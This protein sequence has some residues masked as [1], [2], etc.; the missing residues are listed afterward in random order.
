M[1]RAQCPVCRNDFTVP[2][3]PGSAYPFCSARCRDADL[4]RWFSEGYA[5]PVQGERVLEEAEIELPPE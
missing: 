5:V 2:D 3:G 1:R 4:N